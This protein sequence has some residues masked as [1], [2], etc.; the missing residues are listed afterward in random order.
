MRNGDR[1]G[2]AN[3]GEPGSAGDP[4]WTQ[5]VQRHYEPERDEELVTAIVFA[6]AEAE[7]VAPAELTSSPLYE[8][9]DAAALEESF[10]GPSSADTARQG[11]GTVEFRY[12]D[13]LVTISSD[14]WIQVYD[15]TDGELP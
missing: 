8:H 2:T 13:Y 14:G 6:L 10:F 9:V 11:A 7:R 3:E 4:Q 5:V 15:R 12:L 1:G